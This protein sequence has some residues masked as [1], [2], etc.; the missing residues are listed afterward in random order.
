MPSLPCNP[1][2]PLQPPSARSELFSGAK[3]PPTA[4]CEAVPLKFAHDD[5]CPNLEL[6]SLDSD[7]DCISLSSFGSS[8]SYGGRSD[9][10]RVSF[11]AP[12]VTEV[13]TRPRTQESDKRL[14]FYTQS[15]TDR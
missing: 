10:R 4:P 8:S 1:Y 12:L 14:L 15:E 6:E 7:E 2:P 3:F 5:F 9:E 11:A 13:K